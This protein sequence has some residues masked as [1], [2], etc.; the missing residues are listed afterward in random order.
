MDS[1]SGL[2]TSRERY[3]NVQCSIERHSELHEHFVLVVKLCFVRS[4]ETI[5][6]K[7]I[8]EGVELL[9]EL[10][11]LRKHLIS[12]KPLWSALGAS[13]QVLLSTAPRG[14]AI[15]ERMDFSV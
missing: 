7:R 6:V 13:D 3:N 12:N 1:P 14:G 10:N 2:L 15:R 8:C 9:I 11:G 5:S 4:G